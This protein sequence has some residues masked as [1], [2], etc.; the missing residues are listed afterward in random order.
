MRG[1][2]VW[3]WKAG[4]LWVYGTFRILW[5]AGFMKYLGMEND[6]KVS[7]KVVYFVSISF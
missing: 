6:W 3:D 7:C 1:Q 4:I 2:K 5:K